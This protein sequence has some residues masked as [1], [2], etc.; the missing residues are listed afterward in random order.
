M[1]LLTALAGTLRAS[2]LWGH[3][4]GNSIISLFLCAPAPWLVIPPVVTHLCLGC[5]R[6]VSQPPPSF[7]IMVQYIHRAALSCYAQVGLRLSRLQ[8]TPGKLRWSRKVSL[9]PGTS[10]HTSLNFL[11]IIIIWEWGRIVSVLEGTKI[12]EGDLVPFLLASRLLTQWSPRD[13]SFPGNPMLNPGANR[14]G[15]Y[16]SVRGFRQF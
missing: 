15:A 7:V 5:G 8:V 16:L 12:L 3:G 1:P 11:L 4:P 10:S 6:P 13:G 2:D 14:R 9:E